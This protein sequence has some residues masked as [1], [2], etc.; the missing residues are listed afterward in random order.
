V[1]LFFVNK[2]NANKSAKVIRLPTRRHRQHSYAK[3]E[4]GR[5][6][7]H[8]KKKKCSVRMSARSVRLPDP[9]MEAAAP[10]RRCS[11]GAVGCDMLL[12]RNFSSL[13]SP[14]DLRRRFVL[15]KPW[16]RIM[17]MLLLMLLLLPTISAR[18]VK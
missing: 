1:F 3:Y 10:S 18:K 13:Y 8:F 11:Q 16:G 15:G 17:L 5:G 9:V 4:P 7:L 14:F 6:H 12:P 2:K